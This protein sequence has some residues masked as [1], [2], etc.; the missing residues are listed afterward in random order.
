MADTPQIT[1]LVIPAP[2][3]AVGLLT[4]EAVAERLALSIPTVDRLISRRAL[5]AVRIGRSVRVRVADL[6]RYVEKLEVVR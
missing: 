6:Q 1:P 2:F 3:Q 5:R 4:R